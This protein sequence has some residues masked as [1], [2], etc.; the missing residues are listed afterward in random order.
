[1]ADTW[2]T[3]EQAAVALKLSVRTVNRHITAEKLKSRLSEGR[4]EVLV[5][6]P[7]DAGNN[8]RQAEP[9]PIT[10]APD[11]HRQTAPEQQAPSAS[12]H[13]RLKDLE[14][15]DS[16]SEGREED[17]AADASQA[18]RPSQTSSNDTD[19]PRFDSDMLLALSDNDREK[20]QLA[21]SAYQTLA[22]AAEAQRQTTQRWATFAWLS[23]AVMAVAIILA[24][25][26][27]TRRVTR[28][29][30]ENDQLQQLASDKAALADKALATAEKAQAD[31][32]VIQ[33]QLTDAEAQRARLE[34]RMS[35]LLEA[36]A[37]RPTTHPSLMS[38]LGSIFEGQ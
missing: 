18:R 16:D 25:G 23:V 20:T 26:W 1:M 34:G 29:E 4:R 8:A 31:R 21:V 38:R 36:Q 6:L 37:Q 32:E 19:T 12:V 30:V 27:T 22:R 33:Q 35:A 11:A 15:D 17:E 13:N 9:A 24:V 7:G 3:I 14:A 28:V 2:L 10:P 5:S